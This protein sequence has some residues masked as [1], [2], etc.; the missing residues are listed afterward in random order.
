MQSTTKKKGLTILRVGYVVLVGILL[1]APAACRTRQLGPSPVIA[2]PSALTSN[3]IK[4]AI[5]ASVAGYPDPNAL[6]KSEE[7]TDSALRA[8]LAPFYRSINNQTDGEWFL[9]SVEADAIFAGCQYKQHYL[10]TAIQ[11]DEHYAKIE[12]LEARNLLYD[13][14]HIHKQALV[15]LRTLEL[16]VRRSLSQAALAAQ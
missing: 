2:L 13:G 7:M 9:E 1:L 10:R 11:I 4:F 16:R 14:S 6:T 12:V 3:Q 15:W 5:A 8:L